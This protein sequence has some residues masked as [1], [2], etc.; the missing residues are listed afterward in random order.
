MKNKISFNWDLHYVCN[1]RC[2]YCWFDGRWHELSRQNKYPPLEEVIKAWEKIY[3]RYGSVYIELIGGEPFIYPNFT[4]LI[5]ELSQIHEIGTTTNLSVDLDK[6]I[7]QVDISKVKICPTFHPLFADFSKFIKRVL[8]LKE[9]GMV[10]PVKVNYLAYPPQLKLFDHYKEQFDKFKVPLVVMTFWGNYNGVNYPEGYTQQE[11]VIIEPYLGDRAGKEFQLEPKKVKGKL[12][13]AGQIYADIKA[14][15]TVFRCGG[16]K[17]Q[18]IGNLF[19]DNFNLLDKPMLCESE[20]C[21]CNEWASLLVEKDIVIE[22]KT[23]DDVI[24][25]KLGGRKAM[26]KEEEEEIGQ[27]HFIIV[28]IP[29]RPFKKKEI[30]IDRKK[31]PPYY[32]FFTWDIHYACNYRCTYCNTPKHDQPMDM[33]KERDRK[34]VVYPGLS[35]WIEVWQEI[36]ERYGSSEIHITGGEPFIYPSFIELITTLSKIHTLEIITNLAL[37]VNDVIKNVTPDRVRIGTTFH[38]EF[39]NLNEFIEKHNILRAH[40]FETW[41]NYVLYPPILGKVAEYKSKFDELGIPF[42]MQ[43]YLGFYREKEYPM[44]YSDEELSFLRECYQD[45]DI[46]NKKTIE[47]KTNQPKRNMKGKPCRMGQMYAK[48]YPTGEAYRCCASD[49]LRIGNLIE[50]TFELLNEP[51]PCESEHCFCWRCMLMDNEEGWKQHWVIP[52][53]QPTEA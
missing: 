1:Y 6:F 33:W 18:S 34:K 39:A 17:A 12:C 28:D 22:E 23:G 50:G 41:A 4:E 2:P 35:R 8:Q 52:H 7:N 47:W 40:G 19:S 37:D 13:R 27:S 21:P 42:N 30:T 9:G 5:K 32:V 43:P 29:Q 24:L 51:L 14:D 16:S 15:G 49:V 20:F 48:I 36:Y 53:K 31:I 10:S 45:D 26:T 46:V 38:P 11:K 44:G 25:S 3:V